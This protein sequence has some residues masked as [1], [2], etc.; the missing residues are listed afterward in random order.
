M[1]VFSCKNLSKAYGGRT[2]FSEISFELYQGNRVGL[3]GPNGVGKSTLL[4]ILAGIDESDSGDCNLHAGARSALLAQEHHIVEGRTLIEEARLAMQ[5][6]IDAQAELVTIGE[7]L[8][9]AGEEEHRALTARFDRLN[10]WLQVHSGY[11]IDHQVEEVL[12]GLGFVDADFNRALTTFSGGQ[13]SRVMLAKLLLSA[14]DVMLLDE[15][16][17]HLDIKATEWLEGYLSRQR[18]AMLIVSHDRTFLNNVVTTIFEL[19]ERGVAVYPGNYTAYVR[20][21]QERY[22]LAMKTFEAQQEHIDKQVDYIRKN[23]YGQLARQAQSRA[24]MLDKIERVEKPIQI[25]GPV[26]KFATSRR[27]GDVIVE[28]EHLYKKLGDKQL[29]SDLSF[30]LQ[31]G[32]RLGIM[33]PNGCGKSTLLKLMLGQLKPDQ[34]TIKLGH[35][36]DVGYYDQHLESVM[37]DMTVIRAVW[38]PGDP[39]IT[40]QQMRDF[41]ARFGLFGEM[42]YHKVGSLSGGERSRVVLARIAA[43]NVN[44]LVLDEPTNHLD[45]WACEALE[46]ALAEY[47]GTVIVVSHDRTFLNRVAQMLIVFEDGKVHVVYGNYDTYR[48]LASQQTPV[49]GKL[50]EKQSETTSRSDTNPGAAKVKRKRQFPY[51]KA[52]D[53]EADIASLEAEIEGMEEQLILPEVYKDGIRVR[54]LMSDLEEAKARL[55]G[56]YAHWEEAVELN[57]NE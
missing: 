5:P 37:D 13:Q 19:S 23:N 52:A 50:K 48:G 27:P 57:A 4:H 26:L 6:L 51:R 36:V 2:L 54:E 8:A 15:P 30:Q 38:P 7:Q 29:L 21:R 53:L 40:E 39:T 49:K 3:V 22:D 31:R 25:S 12:H 17:N 42:V 24:K 45:I 11:A 47:E 14:P 1:L 9:T 10:E 56:V 55:P 18:E 28:A 35:Q 20:Q 41:C 16:S 34:G 32:Q 46:E 44:L 43:L 33:G